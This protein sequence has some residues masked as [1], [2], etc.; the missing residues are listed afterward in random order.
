MSSGVVV[1]ERQGRRARKVEEASRARASVEP[2]GEV[3]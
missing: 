2:Y 3:E 1:A